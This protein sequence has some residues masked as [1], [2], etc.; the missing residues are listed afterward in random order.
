MLLDVVFL[1]SVLRV[2]VEV[3]DLPQWFPKSDLSGFSIRGIGIFAAVV[4]SSSLLENEGQNSVDASRTPSR[5]MP[6]ANVMAV[7]PILELEL[8]SRF[9]RLCTP[10]MPDGE[11]VEAK[12]CYSAWPV[13]VRNH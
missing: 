2:E 3:S 13:A 7:V 6:T 11:F 10:G 5:S 1:D 8:D 4:S 9:G 12:N